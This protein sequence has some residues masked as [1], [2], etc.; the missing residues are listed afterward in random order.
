[1][2]YTTFKKIVFIICI[3]QMAW[4]QGQEGIPVYTDYFVDN[5]YLL[6][7]SMAGGADYAKI[8]LTARQQWFDEERAPN[9]QTLNFNA[10]LNEN[11]GIGAILYKDEN[12][13]HSQSGA[14]LTY[15]HHLMFSRGRVELNQLSFGLS[16]GVV[17]AQLDETQF[18]PRDFDPII[19]GIVQSSSYFN[20]DTGVSYNFL[21]FSA[22][23]TVK[24][25]LFTNRRIYSDEFESNNQRS[26]IFSTS[27]FISPRSIDWAFEPSLLISYKERTG[28]GFF[29][30]NAKAYKNLG[31]ARI[32]GG[33]SYRRSFDGA[34]YLDGEE[35]KDQNLQY[36][37]PVLGFNYKKF[38]FAYTYSYQR[39]NVRFDSG[40]YH[41]ITLGYN[42]FKGKVNT[43][44]Q[45]MRYN[46]MLRPRGY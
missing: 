16:A 28:E 17:Q 25:L 1:M 40:G 15:A 3:V 9:I 5:L 18:D 43:W 45:D 31:I 29:D 34:Q 8:R 27:Y 24:N 10:R 37:T 13:Y 46:G 14:F 30:V 11:S 44:S 32:W 26:Y 38:I 23:F 21:N 35:I 19:A 42:I 36:I 39:G 22:H 7:P 2:R 4:V 12:G 6:H 41:Q 33:V 20:V